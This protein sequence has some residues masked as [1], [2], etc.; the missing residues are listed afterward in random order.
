MI[1]M[2]DNRYEALIVFT[3][4]FVYNK[5][6]QSGPTITFAGNRPW[7]RALPA[8]RSLSARRAFLCAAVYHLFLLAGYN[9]NRPPFDYAYGE[10]LLPF[11]QLGIL[12]L[13]DQ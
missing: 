3:R 6:R 2:I 13:L 7:Q 1:D 10:Y 9:P 5:D 11:G 8:R 4:L 12:D